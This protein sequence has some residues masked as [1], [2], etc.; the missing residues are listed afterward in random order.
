MSAASALPRVGALLTFA[1]PVEGRRRAA[2][3]LLAGAAVLAVAYVG[4]VVFDPLVSTSRVR[5]WQVT[6]A[7][8]EAL[9]A[10]AILCVGTASGVD[11]RSR[12]AWTWLALGLLA[13]A[14][15]ASGVAGESGPSALIA[16]WGW[17]FS[18]PCF[19]IGLLSFPRLPLDR[20]ERLRVGLDGTILLISAALLLWYLG[21]LGIRIEG[22][23]KFATF[24]SFNVIVLLG[25]ALLLYVVLLVAVRTPERT[26]RASWML[27]LAVFAVSIIGDVLY[28]AASI[29]AGSPSMPVGV[30]QLLWAPSAW[31]LGLAAV[32]ETRVAPAAVEQ[33]TVVPKPV[34]QALTSVAPYGA[35]ALL[36]IVTLLEGAR[37]QDVVFRVLAIGMV[38]MAVL[39]T[40]RLV[41]ALR[42]N[43][44][45]LAEQERQAE[46][47]RESQKLEAIGRLAGGI[48]HEFNNLLMVIQQ[49]SEA[50]L[51]RNVVDDD[52]RDVQ[53]AA[54]R[55]AELTRQL[56]T[57][58][59]REFTVGAT[60]PVLALTEVQPLLQRLLRPDIVLDVEVLAGVGH[61]SLDRGGVDQV[62]F[63][64][65]R[66]GADAITGSGR[67]T[68]RL[69]PSPRAGFVRLRVTDTG[70]GM[71]ESVRVL[72][73]E[74]FFST[75]PVGQGTGLGLAIV[76][77]LV[78][79]AGGSIDV[80][81][82]EGAGTCFTVDLPIVLAGASVPA[83][84]PEIPV[85][86]E[87]HSLPTVLLVDDEPT[88]RRI[89]RRTL[90]RLGYAVQEAEDGAEALALLDEGTE[91]GL[92]LTDTVMPKV[93]GWELI[94]EVRRRHPTLPIIRM[95]GFA[96][97]PDEAHDDQSDVFLAKPFDI[98]VLQQTV[99]NLMASRPEGR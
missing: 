78:T 56:L 91:V 85:P 63:N 1:A 76:H 45:L 65:V 88:V 68:I 54:T 18:F 16:D 98:G 99:Q 10:V 93:D 82:A 95:S 12:R 44:V 83:S 27:L 81:T 9:T 71:P 50:I 55:A 38:V 29:G 40:L 20:R 35:T 43:A 80:E 17:L 62:L 48:A 52:A 21:T 92:V 79:G 49:G 47:F 66:N 67:I 86:A 39:V 26:R 14:V 4:A 59:R 90:E 22:P 11:G 8:M 6:Y 70:S 23:K 84:P 30:P 61:V 74:P 69:L 41:L 3:W 28:V 72:L 32:L 73:F 77:G 5:P 89:L 60:D 24:H 2:Q 25:N 57:F 97:P 51:A 31:F 87:R 7:V 75:K 36:A 96:E 34:R 19:C 15:S 53:A 46:Q 64:L 13:L 94:R 33:G 37:L 42:E 58:S